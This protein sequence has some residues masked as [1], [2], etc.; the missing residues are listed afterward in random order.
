MSA[1]RSKSVFEANDLAPCIWDSAEAFLHPWY[2][3]LSERQC[4]N[5]KLAEVSKRR[6]LQLG[7]EVVTDLSQSLSH[8]TITVDTCP[9]VIPVA[10]FWLLRRRR[11]MSGAEKLRM[12]NVFINFKN[13]SSS[14]LWSD[15]AGNAYS[16]TTFR[17]VFLA[18]MMALEEHVAR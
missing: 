16:S 8:Q 18:M 15:L 11:I 9:C 5:L 7:H 10:E 12:Q 4:S 13:D 2:G 1:T 6:E 17:A 3:V 14:A